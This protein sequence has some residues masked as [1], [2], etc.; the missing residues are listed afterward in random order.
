M[1]GTLVVYL[2]E[3]KDILRDRRTLVSM[4][5][6]PLLFYPIVTVGVG[7]VISSQ[8]ESARAGSQPI[9]VLPAEGDPGLLGMLGADSSLTIANPDSVRE[10]LL[11][12]ASKDSALNRDLIDEVFRKPP[13]MVS[14]EAKQPVYYA[15]ISGEKVRAVVEVPPALGD[16][17]A[18][19][20]SVAVALY[21]DDADL[22]S[23]FA[24]ELIE[25]V[26][27]A[28]RDSLIAGRLRDAGLDTRVLSPFVVSSSSVAPPAKQSG[29]FLAMFLP[30]M[31]LILTFSGGMYAA[32]DITAGEKERNTLE[33]LLVAPVSRWQIA[34][35]KFLAVMT[36]GLVTM[37]L[38]IISMV[39]SM[40]LGP[41]AFDE[42]SAAGIQFSMTTEMAVWMLLLMLPMAIF[43]SA[44][45]VTVSISA[46]SFKEAQSYVTP[47]L[48]AFI[49]PAMVTFVPGIKLNFALA[50]VPV[51]NLCLAI[52]DVLL[53]EQQA[54]LTLLVL[55][56][57]SLYAA[58]MVF[59]TARMFERESVMFRT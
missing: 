43:T 42:S 29:R 22:K 59:V 21:V 39:G 32:L 19:G 5:L 36:A 35:G 45:L 30:Y 40:S 51:V 38:A 55:G 1:N 13:G 47:I 33:S 10:W 23:E 2:K 7:K 50:F 31:L 56:I 58:F 15:L 20:D 26:A 4:V 54:A 49:I 24:G 41:Q 17:P 52:R 27:L 57:T 12:Q 9:L 3:M 11:E 28:Q 44:L 46:R 48:L 34:S 37:V 18:E 25:G 14:F 6:V 53:G 16:I 8:I